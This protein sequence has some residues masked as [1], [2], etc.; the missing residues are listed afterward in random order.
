MGVN[1][2]GGLVAV[3]VAVDAIAAVAVS[4]D[5]RVAVSGARLHELVVIMIAMMKTASR[6]FIGRFIGSS[7]TSTGPDYERVE[8]KAPTNCQQLRKST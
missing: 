7:Q 3:D 8:L 2:G 1:V 5:T 4:V 6:L